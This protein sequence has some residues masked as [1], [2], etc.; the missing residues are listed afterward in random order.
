M[1]LIFAT[2]LTAVATVALAVLALA[3]AILAGLAFRKQSREV[4]I[5]IEESKRQA[6]ER[7]RAQAARV[8]IAISTDP[9]DKDRPATQN[10][11]DYPTFDAQLWYSNPRGLMGP[12][13]LHMMLPGT[14]ASGT[15][16]MAAAG[17]PE[18]IL[19]FRDA[20]GVRWIRMA[21]GSFDEQT[22]DTASNTVRAALG[23]APPGTS[24]AL[25]NAP[26]G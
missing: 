26:E 2:Q 9:A 10:A 16:L 5:L 19:T 20:E 4:G 12:D 1:S 8:F 7:R 11:S 6:R 17:Y 18:I 22:H 3:A 14:T 21:D 25:E 23:M 13:D 15:L 24:Q